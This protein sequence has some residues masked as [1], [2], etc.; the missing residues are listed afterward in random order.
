MNAISYALDQIQYEIPAEVL[1]EAFMP[2][3][4]DPARRERYRDN[5]LGVSIES[6][7]RK[8]VVEGRVATDINLCSGVETIVSLRN[9]PVEQTDQW[10]YIYRIPD[11]LTGGRSITAVYGVTFGSGYTTFGGTNMT[12]QS[13]VLM[14]AAQGVMQSHLPIP[15]TNSP[16]VTL[17][18]ENT[19]MISDAQG[20]NPDM[21]LRCQVTHEPNFANIKPGYYR[22]FA[23]LAVLAA[24]GI[25]YNRLII[26]LDEGQ[27]K[28]G[29]NIGRFREVVDSY[30]D[31]NQMYK[32][33]LNDKWRV[34]SVMSDTE[35][36]R[37]ILKMAVGGLR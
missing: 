17:I 11:T 3:R 27:I 2:R 35:K 25:I 19:V 34:S 8:E 36:Y 10:N 9:V 20:M 23:D 22:K 18:G 16:Y 13:S 12:N 4:Y 37:Q 1:Q 32:E 31:A 29:S 7:I 15:N 6:I 24:K 33:L 30:A 5:Q 14:N 28:A 21:W 26:L